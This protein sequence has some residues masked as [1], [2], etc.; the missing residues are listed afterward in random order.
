MESAPP[1]R[2]CSLVVPI[3]VL[4]AGNFKGAAEVENLK[5]HIDAGNQR[6]VDY[7]RSRG[8]QAQAFSAV[9]HD[10]VEKAV[11]IAP[12]ILARF[13]NAI[14]FGGQL[15]FRQETLLTRLLHNY[16]VFA[17]QRRFYQRGLPLLILPIR[18]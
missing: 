4:D 10:V 5:R 16:A 9:G 2:A 13:P 1:S 11:D 8:F 15:V 17:L 6:Y 14:F 7:M 18:I 12:D 3:G